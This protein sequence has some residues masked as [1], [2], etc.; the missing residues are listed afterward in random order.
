[1]PQTESQKAAQAKYRA[2]GR[3]QVN[4]EL[5]LK[6]RETWKAFAKAQGLSLPAMVREAVLQSMQAQGWE[7]E[8]TEEN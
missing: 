2:K 6:D 4:I 5:N 1:M 8:Q 3:V 7:N